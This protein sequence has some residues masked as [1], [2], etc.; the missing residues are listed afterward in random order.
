VYNNFKAGNVSPGK[1]VSVNPDKVAVATNLSKTE[2]NYPAIRIIETKLPKFEKEVGKF[3]PTVA[4]FTNNRFGYPF[5]AEFHPVPISHG[6]TDMEII[7]EKFKTFTDEDF[8]K[9]EKY[10]EEINTINVGTY[11]VEKETSDWKNYPDVEVGDR[12]AMKAPAKKI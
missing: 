10:L 5:W 1:V 8:N 12:F 3:I 9:V 6:T 7:N 11:K 4:L 2:N